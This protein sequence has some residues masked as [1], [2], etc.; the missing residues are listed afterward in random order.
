MLLMEQ[1]IPIKEDT[2]NKKRDF[3]V[4]KQGGYLKWEWDMEQLMLFI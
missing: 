2:I 1:T 4:N 3:K